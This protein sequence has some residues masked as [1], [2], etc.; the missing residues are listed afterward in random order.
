MKKLLTLLILS[1][2]S[3]ACYAA[4]A[5]WTPL[6]ESMKKGC[7]VDFDAL[8]YGK[9]DM[10]NCLPNTAPPLPAAGAG[11]QSRMVKH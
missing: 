8:P 5:D 7:A 9:S 6:L 4:A 2:F 10:V 3:S 11:R 1:A